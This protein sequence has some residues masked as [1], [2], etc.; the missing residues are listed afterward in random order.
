VS[1]FSADD[2]VS[3][4][5]KLRIYDPFSI[6][7]VETMMNET[8]VEIYGV[9]I[10]PLWSWTCEFG[11]NHVH[12]YVIEDGKRFR[13]DFPGILLKSFASVRICREMV[14]CASY[15]LKYP[16]NKFLSFDAYPLL[17]HISGGIKV[18]LQTNYTFGPESAC[19]F[20]EKEVNINNEIDD[21]GFVQYFCMSPPMDFPQKMHLSISIDGTNFSLRKVPFQYISYVSECHVSPSHIPSSRE[22][23]IH[24]LGPLLPDLSGLSCSFDGEPALSAFRVSDSELWCTSPRITSGNKTV[25]LIQRDNTIVMLCDYLEVDLHMTIT[26]IHPKFGYPDSR[27]IL[28]GKT[29]HSN[30]QYTCRF[31]TNTSPAVYLNSTSV[32][33]KVPVYDSCSGVDLSLSSN[34]VYYIYF[35]E[36]FIYIEAPSIISVNPIVVDVARSGIDYFLEGL[37]IK[38]VESNFSCQIGNFT[39]IAVSKTPFGISCRLSSIITMGAYHLYITSLY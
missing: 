19:R 37:N 3:T 20:G 38:S 21:I 32:S 26:D 17:G 33:C 27:V 6:K 30:R 12:G 25:H 36:V 24:I 31:G 18:I 8:G 9:G 7:S 15:S 16:T 1:I 29:F 34:G 13:C 22:L 11:E 28:H 2:R 10:N 14:D 5:I 4:G 23:S 35:P 39:S